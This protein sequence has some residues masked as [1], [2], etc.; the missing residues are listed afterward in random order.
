MHRTNVK[1]FI[2]IILNKPDSIQIFQLNFALTRVTKLRLFSRIEHHIR[3][4]HRNKLQ[5]IPGY[6]MQ[7]IL[8]LLAQYINKTNVIHVVP[9]T[10][11]N[12]PDTC[13]SQLKMIIFLISFVIKIHKLIRK[14]GARVQRNT[15]PFCHSVR[16]H[17]LQCIDL[18]SDPARISIYLL[19]LHSQPDSP[20]KPLKKLHSKRILQCFDHLTHT[21]LRRIKNLRRITERTRLCTYYKIL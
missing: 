9:D 12:A 4:I 7:K 6:F 17:I 13:S 14:P 11:H 19:P 18:I 16:R 15:D 21:R 1:K 20:W 3:L 8:L 5:L 2:L 10:I